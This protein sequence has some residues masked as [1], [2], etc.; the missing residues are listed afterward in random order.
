MFNFNG[1]VYFPLTSGKKEINVW[2]YYFN[3]KVFRNVLRFFSM[4]G[5]TGFPRKSY[6]DGVREGGFY[7]FFR[8]PPKKR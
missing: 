8:L 5:T 7:L 1:A 2:R 6:G 3:E 4:C